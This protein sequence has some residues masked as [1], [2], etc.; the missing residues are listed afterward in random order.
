MLIGFDHDD[1]L[2]QRCIINAVA[3]SQYRKVFNIARMGWRLPRLQQW[4]EGRFVGPISPDVDI[5]HLFNCIP[6]KTKKPWVCTF[7][8]VVPRYDATRTAH[9][10]ASPD[11]GNISS[12]PRCLAARRAITSP[13]CLGLL[14]LSE[15][16]RRMELSFLASMP[17]PDP[18]IERKMIVLPPPQPIIATGA[19]HRP[20]TGRNV[21][22]LFVGRAFHRKG[23]MEVIR[24]LARLR[25]DH[26][27]PIELTVVSD[28][29]LDP[30]A[31][32]ETVADI[33][34]ARDLLKANAEW[35][36]WPGRL[37]NRAILGLMVEAHVGLLPTHADTYGLSVLECQASA[38]PVITTD[39]RAMPEINTPE[40]G[41]LIQVPKNR[42]GE[43][44]YTTADERRTLSEAIETGLENAVH[45]IFANLAE[46]PRKA[47]A[48][49]EHIRQ[50]H[51][52]NTY[53]AR[54]KEIYEGALVG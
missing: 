26:R 21:K 37:G 20:A 40:T 51:D 2:Q 53:G 12:S 34:A 6:M 41:W 5:L 54:L 52:P 48:A 29:L 35:I 14:P 32:R 50:H 13:S 4:T 15:C 19:T 46:L 7:E 31:T 27:Y 42:L 28:L 18:S 30:Y 25:R 36:T 24:T 22:F 3:G 44:I 47:A 16:N 45:E 11:Y 23:G 43:A 1:Y 8:T 49:L 10:G 39:V 38:C 33:A 17:A 9:W